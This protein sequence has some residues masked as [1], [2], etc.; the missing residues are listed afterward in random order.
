MVHDNEIVY[1]AK[2]ELR[3]SIRTSLK[4]FWASSSAAE[5][6]RLGVLLSEKIKKVPA[7]DSCAH[8]CAFLSMPDEL[9]TGPLITAALNQNKHVYVP[10]IEGS[11]IDFVILETDWNS[12]TKDAWNIPVPPGELPAVKP[13][14]FIQEPSLIVVPGLAFDTTGRRL[15][16]G[17]GFYDRYLGKLLAVSKQ[18]Q[19]PMPFLVGVGLE[20]Q[21]VESVP[22]D[23]HDFRVDTVIVI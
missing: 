8:I 7:W 22:A 10:R 9:D 6:N 13:E 18:L 20:L 12:W 11:D 16:R 4:S 15:G 14:L 1:Q 2:K 23:D 19:K 21:L 3:K 17:K 5:K